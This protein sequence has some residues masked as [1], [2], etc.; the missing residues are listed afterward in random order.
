MLTDVLHSARSSSSTGLVQQSGTPSTPPLSVASPSSSFTPTTPTLLR[1][2]SFSSIHAVQHMPSLLRSLSST[3]INNNN[4]ITYNNEEDDLDAEDEKFA[5]ELNQLLSE[6]NDLDNIGSNS[7]SER[8]GDQ[9]NE[10]PRKKLKT[11]NSTK[12]QVAY[13]CV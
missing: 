12:Q 6:E 11:M 9:D 13:N 8:T 7:D 5:G 1:P 3:D 4:N 2:S 10:Q